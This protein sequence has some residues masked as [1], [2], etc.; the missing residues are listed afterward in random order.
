MLALLLELTVRM[1]VI[2]T[3]AF[4]F[5][6]I[7][8]FKRFLSQM[9]SGR[10][11]VIITLGF[12]LFTLL[13]TYFGI[14]VQ[15]AI[16][17]SRAVG[18]V[19]AGLLGGPWVGVGAGA[20]A[21]LHRWWLG[22]FTGFACGLSTTLEGLLGGLVATRVR[23]VD[24]EVGLATGLAAELMQMAILLLVAR[25]FSASLELVKVIGVP[26]TLV[27]GAGVAIFITML[28]SL[29]A[30]V[31]RAGAAQTQKVLE[32]ARLSLPHLKK[33]LTP[34]SAMFTARIILELTGVD[35]VALTDRQVV[36]AHVGL[37][38]DHH[39]PGYPFVTRATARV[40]EEGRLQVA[41]T[42]ED[43]GCNNPH[44][45]LGSGVIV[46]LYC[47][48]RIVGALKLY[49][50]R[51]EGITPVDM[52][53]ASGLSQLFSTQLELAEASR[54]AEL[55]AQAE[56]TA[57]QA[58]I[59]PHFLFNAINTIVSYCRTDPNTAR[60]LLLNLAAYFR[61]NLE[62]AGDFCTLAEELVH[63]NAYLALE[64]ARY[65][66]RL[67]LVEEIPAELKGIKLP[68]L[69]LEPLVENAVKHGIA[70]RTE[71]GTVLIRAQRRGAG[72]Y[73]AVVDTGVG[74]LPETLA[75]VRKGCPASGGIGLGNVN[76]RLKNVYGAEHGLQIESTPGEGTCVSF[77]LPEEV[78]E[79]ACVS[80]R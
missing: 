72:V 24:W 35:A 76:E 6:R 52:E 36:L 12:G 26:M 11:K 22:G 40:L 33:G 28:R 34:R 75:E 53:V 44:C 25:P 54:R 14:D 9:A 65:G 45:P 67:K 29:Q 8:V 74:M 32:I 64:Q 73:L 43:I 61:R 15:G 30:E 10:D 37:G 46:P 16:A 55:A 49:R 66:D 71:G 19:V 4:L 58:Q 23:K 78:A 38:A 39:L 2:S 18:A 21:G 51:P 42:R 80:A 62:R 7:P 79:H 3:S 20:I 27:N 41:Q 68:R 60:Q 47:Q 13:G 31:D 57:L 5:S 69:T 77:W 50:T 70:P 1:C 63:V 17:N 56:L 59:N 48:S